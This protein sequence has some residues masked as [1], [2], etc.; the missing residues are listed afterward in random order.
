M[1]SCYVPNRLGVEWRATLSTR[2]HTP[3]WVQCHLSHSGSG[4][5]ADRGQVIR[6]YWL[7]LHFIR[8][9]GTALISSLWVFPTLHFIAKC[10]PSQT[11]GKV[12]ILIDPDVS[13]EER[14]SVS[15]FST[16]L[17]QARFL[18]WQGSSSL[19]LS[20]TLR[21]LTSPGRCPEYTSAS[22]FSRPSQ[23]IT[24]KT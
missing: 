4:P 18:G 22:N 24:H 21:V 7:I 13:N 20:G 5:W 9:K 23:W 14:A 6:G 15:S 3:V 17:S 16:R 2:K 11:G 19:G 10:S 8:M 1:V 12:S